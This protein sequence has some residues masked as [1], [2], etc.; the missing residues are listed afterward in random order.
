MKCVVP[1]HCSSNCIF[2]TIKYAGHLFFS[3]LL[4]SVCM[5]NVDLICLPLLA[6]NLFYGVLELF[7]NVYSGYKF[8]IRY[9]ISTYFL[10]LWLASHSLGMEEQKFLSFGGVRVTNIF[11]YSSCFWCHI[12]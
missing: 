10:N 9:V 2:L 5:C 7:K 4:A 12:G 1:F 8:F 6:L 3:Q 11:F